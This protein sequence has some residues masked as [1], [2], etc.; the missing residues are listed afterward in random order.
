[1]LDRFL[2]LVS[3][4]YSCRS[5]Q[6]RPVEEEKLAYIKECMRLAPSAVNRQPWRFRIVRSQEG[7][8]KLQSCYSRP[9]FSEAPLYILGTV[10][11]E[12]QWVRADGK[13]HGN[14]DVAIAG[15]HLCLAATEQGLGSCWVCNFD[16]RLCSELFQL[17]AAEE[18]VV[19]IPLGYAARTEVPPKRRKAMEDVFIE[20]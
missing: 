4:R 11:N 12:E 20:E 19:I 5:Y 7:R 1:M 15:E 9:W 2:D 6:D 8:A 17:P 18:P 10:L 13:A 3:S 16:A 14:I